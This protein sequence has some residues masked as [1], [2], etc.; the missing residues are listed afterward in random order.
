MPPEQRVFPD[1]AD[2]GKVDRLIEE[3]GGVDIAFGGI[4]INGHLAFNESRED[5]TAEA[6][7]SGD[8]DIGH[9]TQM[10]DAYAGQGPFA[11][12]GPNEKIL[13]LMNLYNV[14]SIAIVK[15]DKRLK[16]GS[17]RICVSVLSGDTT[18]SKVHEFNIST[19]K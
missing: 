4:G 9:T 18:I 7:T 2:P 13:A 11:E 10:Y 8:L 12:D 3:L 5:M 17:V 16:K 15:A 14:E 1:P 6:P 19:S